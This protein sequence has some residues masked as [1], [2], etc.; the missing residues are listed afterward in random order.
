MNTLSKRLRLENM[1]LN[2]LPYLV[3]H[4]DGG[5]RNG[6][7]MLP[8]GGG[9]RLEQSAFLCMWAVF[10]L[11]VVL[12]KVGDAP[13]IGLQG[14]IQP[15]KRKSSAICYRD[16]ATDRR[17]L[18]SRSGRRVGPARLTRP[19][20]R[21]HG[22]VNGPARRRKPLSPISISLRRTATARS[23]VRAADRPVSRRNS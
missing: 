12:V 16:V 11:L 13:R 15:V 4:C 20:G 17:T 3:Q 8:G 9:R 21:T 6:L 5:S 10:W 14:V 19:A 18:R 2:K 22:C 7:E 1:C 23:C